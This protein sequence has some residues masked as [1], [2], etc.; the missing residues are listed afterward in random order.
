LEPEGWDESKHNLLSGQHPYF[1]PLEQKSALA[2]KKFSYGVSLTNVTNSAL[3]I[4]V[5][6]YHR[7][8]D[9]NVRIDA[10]RLNP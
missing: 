9:A 5:V 3:A 7:Y 10:D 8:L 1:A 2:S 6:H 4:I